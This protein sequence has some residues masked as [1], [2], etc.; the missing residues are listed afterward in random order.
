[1][2]LLEQI[3]LKIT[4]SLRDLQN[5][6]NYFLMSLAVADLLVCLIVMPFGAIT[7]FK[8]ERGLMVVF[9]HCDWAVFSRLL[10]ALSRLVCLLPDLRRTGLLGLHP[11]PHVHL[12]RFVPPCPACLTNC[13]CLQAATEESDDHCAREPRAN[14]PSSTKSFSPGVSASSWPPRYLSSPSS[15]SATSCRPTRCARWTTSTSWSSGPCWLSTSPW[16]LWWPL[17]FWQFT[18][19]R[20]RSS[21]LWLAPGIRSARTGR[22]RWQVWEKIY[23]N[24][25]NQ[26]IFA[27][28]PRARS[29]LPDSNGE[30]WQQ[31]HLQ[32]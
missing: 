23:F 20:N 18:I 17:T 26:I 1:M 5:M 15:T 3:I 25:A 6:T 8:G 29:Q 10:A 16:W 28:H 27:F 24:S 12:H 22:W 32:L 7:F 11:P 31:V 9:V 13:W 4:S 30:K 21:P 19:W 2:E 14:T